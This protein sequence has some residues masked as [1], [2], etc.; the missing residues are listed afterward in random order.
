MM[1]ETTLLDRIDGIIPI[2]AAAAM[3]LEQ[4]LVDRIAVC[5]FFRAWSRMVLGLR[6]VVLGFLSAR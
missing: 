5:S 2:G 1:D 6:I 3:H 4:G